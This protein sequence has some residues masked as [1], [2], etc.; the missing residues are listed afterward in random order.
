MTTTKV[1]KTSN[2]NSELFLPSFTVCGSSGYKQ[3]IDEYRDLN[4]VNY[5]NNT[6]EL[7]DLQIEV[8]QYHN[9]VFKSE[10]LHDTTLEN[11]TSW[12]ISTTYGAYRGRCYTIEY[13]EKVFLYYYSGFQTSLS[14]CKNIF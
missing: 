2:G 11:S 8:V 4:L 14:F 5:L 1:L 6:L 3:I 10:T 9:G 12:K 13:M 7:K